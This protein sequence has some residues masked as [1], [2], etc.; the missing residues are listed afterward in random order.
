[1]VDK[2]STTAS[3]TIPPSRRNR[4]NTRRCL[5]RPKVGARLCRQEPQSIFKW[6][7]RS[8]WNHHKWPCHKRRCSRHPTSRPSPH[9]Q[10]HHS[11]NNQQRPH[12]PYHPLA[13]CPAPQTLHS[14]IPPLHPRLHP[15]HLPQKLPLGRHRIPAHNVLDLHRRRPPH[16]RPHQPFLITR[17]ENNSHPARHNPNPSH[18]TPP[19]SSSATA[20]SNSPIRSTLTNYTTTRRVHAAA[21]S[22]SCKNSKPSRSRGSAYA[23]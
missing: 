13:R 6:Y 14:A 23:P 15:N 11:N 10:R 21:S 3:G 8:Q 20:C 1:V 2:A 22:K 16:L 19:T 18:T 17:Q 12:H 9:P 4:T 7:S 5:A